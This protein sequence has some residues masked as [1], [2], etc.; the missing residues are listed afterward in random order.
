MRRIIDLT[1]PIDGNLPNASVEPH[2][3]IDRDGWRATM[4]RLYS[5][6]GTHMDATCHFLPHGQSIDELNLEACCGIATVVDLSPAEPSQSISVEEFHRALGRDLA[7]GERLLI[8]T[9]W[10]RRYRAAEY[11]DRLPRI[12]TELANWFAHHQVRLVGVE[13]PSVADVNDLSEVTEIHHILFKAGIVII[14]GL[15]HLDQIG[16]DR[17]Q[18]IA[19]PLRIVGGDGCPVRAIAIV[20]DGEPDPVSAMGFQTITNTETH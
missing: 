7:P 9:D 11:R 18:F 20:G 10:Y 15:A 14:E 12:S 2:K 17:C 4:L 19:L 6:C 16:T 1:L 13:P 5:H 3:S 8:R